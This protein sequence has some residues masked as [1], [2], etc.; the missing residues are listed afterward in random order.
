MK[1]EETDAIRKEILAVIDPH[2]KVNDSFKM[3]HLY[4]SDGTP[5]S[6]DKDAALSV[7][8]V[9]NG[10]L[11]KCHRCQAE[12]FIS[13]KQKS[14]RDTL[15]MIEALRSKPIKAKR[16]ATLPYDYVPLI[17]ARDRMDV[18]VA[19]YHWLWQYDLRSSDLIKHEIGYSKAYRRV[20]I[21]VK[22][23]GHTQLLGWIGRELD[24]DDKEKRK[25]AKVP[26]YLTYKSQ[27]VKRLYFMIRGGVDDIVVLVEDVIS[28]IKINK[29]T[30]LSTIALLG[31]YMDEEVLKQ[32]QGKKVYV[33]LDGDAFQKAVS[34]VERLS[35][36]GVEARVVHT[37]KDPKDHRE[38]Q[39]YFHLASAI[40]PREDD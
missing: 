26:K 11:Y 34:Y 6:K 15:S 9:Y 31:T 40:P 27:L 29:F 5:C 32:L 10:W 13:D 23:P 24:F 14:P 35:Q 16:F 4:K 12:G 18:P 21:P 38:D 20:I 17:N 33:W 2:L 7:K 30:D 39:I 19:A 28:A 3:K 1:N 22:R 25:E 36:L 37:L 8:R